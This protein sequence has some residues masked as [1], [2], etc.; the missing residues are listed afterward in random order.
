MRRRGSEDDEREDRVLLEH[1]LL[2]QTGVQG[3]DG[4][5]CEGDGLQGGKTKRSDRVNVTSCW[6]AGGVSSSP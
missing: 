1:M 4:E 6:A 3:E 2:G 5:G